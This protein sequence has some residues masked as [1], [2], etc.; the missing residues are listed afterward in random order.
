MHQHTELSFVD[1]FR[2]VSPLHYLKNGWQTLFFFGACC[3]RGRHLYTTTA[4]S[5]CIPASYCHLSAT[6]QT[7]SSIVVN[8]QDNRAVFR[9]FIALLKFSFDSPSYVAEC[10]IVGSNAVQSV[11]STAHGQH[12]TLNI[13]TLR[14]IK[15]TSL[16][17]SPAHQLVRLC[18]NGK[19]RAS[20]K[21]MGQ[22]SFLEMHS[23]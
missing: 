13:L 6:L 16:P 18:R 12:V 10:A 4:P 1:E 19:G 3:K 8:L 15:V 11:I 17:V 14:N 20:R 7:M 21:I 2:R 22:N 9:I 5:C 23:S